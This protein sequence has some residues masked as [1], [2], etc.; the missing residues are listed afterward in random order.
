MQ[1][2]TLAP[3]AGFG[4]H[5]HRDMEIVTVVTGGTLSHKDSL[6]SAGTV[7]AGEVQVMSAGTGI[8]HS[9]YN[10]SPDEP[11]TLF[12]IWILPARP[13]GAPRYEQKPFAAVPPAG[14]VLPLVSP[15]GADGTLRIGQDAFIAKAS[16]D[17]AHP[18]TYTL[19]H[20]GN[21]VYVFVLDGALEAEGVP[22][23]KRDALGITGAAS[24]ALAAKGPATVLLLEVPV[25]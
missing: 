15:D 14:A 10:A 6:G 23:E 20:G 1:P 3:G 13:G 17:A 7:R 2:V 16:V 25:G 12:Q 4:T 19:K 8:I 22:L 21:G 9:E 24:V 11:L 5:P 18:L